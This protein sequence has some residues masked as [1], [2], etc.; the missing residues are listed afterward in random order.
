MN[1]VT[2]MQDLLDRKNGSPCPLCSVIHR[3]QVQCTRE[4][5]ASKITKLLEANAMIP[6]LL[7]HNKEATQIAS[8]LQHIVKKADEA[9]NILMEVLSNHGEIG[10]TIQREYMERLD[11]WAANVPSNPDTTVQGEL[12][13]QEPSTSPETETLRET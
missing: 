12:F 9:H 4:H 5:L 1:T 10:E 2:S 7:Q 11:K 8:G 3:P 13:S 6:G